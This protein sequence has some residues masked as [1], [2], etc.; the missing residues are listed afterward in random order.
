MDCNYTFPIDL[1]PNW[2]SVTA[3]SIGKLELQSKFGWI[4]Q[5]SESISLCVVP[6]QNSKDYDRIDNFLVI[7]NQK[8]FRLVHIINKNSSFDYRLQK[9]FF[10]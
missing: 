3:K 8:D 9:T 5:D 2:I 4:Y 7:M 10:R 1:P 6:F